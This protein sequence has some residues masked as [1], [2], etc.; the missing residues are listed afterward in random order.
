MSKRVRVSEK[1]DEARFRAPKDVRESSA[2]SRSASP[3]STAPASELASSSSLSSC[4]VRSNGSGVFASFGVSGSM[5]ACFVALP[6]S[7]SHFGLSSM[8]GA[9]TSCKPATH[10]ETSGI[11]RQFA[12]TCSD[13]KGMLTA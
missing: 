4:G 3:A 12:S 5:S 10:A 13:V 6:Y 7:A 1:Y 8:H 9:L 11:Q 2:S